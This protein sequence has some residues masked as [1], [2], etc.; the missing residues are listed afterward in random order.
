MDDSMYDIFI[1]IDDIDINTLENIKRR[2]MNVISDIESNSKILVHCK[3]DI[4]NSLSKIPNQYLDNII[5][6]RYG[7]NNNYGINN[8]QLFLQSFQS[9]Q[10]LF[11]LQ[12]LYL[13]C[14]NISLRHN[15]QGIERNTFDVSLI[16]NFNLDNLPSTLKSLEL[17]CIGNNLIFNKQLNNLPP[18]LEKLDIVVS[19]F[20]QPLDMLPITLKSLSLNS[21]TFNQ[22]LNNL[23]SNLE[24]LA[25]GDKLMYSG[26]I[27]TLTLDNLPDSIKILHICIN[28]S[29]NIQ[30]LPKSIK[31]IR[32]LK[33]Y[34]YYDELQT[35]VA[36]LNDERNNDKTA[37]QYLI[38]LIGF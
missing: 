3:N 31:E 34:A 14:N 13:E 16:N 19:Y 8:L 17:N 38:Q 15:N 1:D 22:S 24:Y 10:I 30:K 27:F 23:P 6:L 33:N 12:D 28:I 35:M 5:G 20:N 11:N 36:R 18:K 2:N 29:Q 9:L 32:I 37:Q 25:F 7:I 21:K 26:T 4:I